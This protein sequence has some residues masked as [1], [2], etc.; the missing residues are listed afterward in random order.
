MIEGLLCQSVG[1]SLKTGVPDGGIGTYGSPTTYPARVEPYHRLMKSG[2]GSMKQTSALIYLGPTATVSIGDRIT[3]P[4]T[5][6]WEVVSVEPL[7]GRY[8]QLDHYE[9][10]V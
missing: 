1:V 9:V 6:S 3:L 5:T 8:G 7:Y 4:D 10:I 2:D